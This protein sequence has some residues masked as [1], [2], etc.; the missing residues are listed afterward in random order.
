MHNHFTHFDISAFQKCSAVRMLCTHTLI[1]YLFT[2][3]AAQE[4]WF[5]QPAQLLIIIMLFHTYFVSQ[6]ESKVHPDSFLYFWG[7]EQE[8]VFYYSISNSVALT[9]WKF[10][11]QKFSTVDFF[12]FSSFIHQKGISSNLSERNFVGAFSYFHWI[13]FPCLCDFT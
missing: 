4:L 11:C 5:A 10:S 3:S 13:L 12:S 8:T 6:I 7:E 1:V 9:S 2:N